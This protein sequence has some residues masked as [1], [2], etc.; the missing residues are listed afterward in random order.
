MLAM[1]SPFSFR[2]FGRAPAD[3]DALPSAPTDTAAQ[4]FP[5]LAPQVG[6]AS[7]IH[8]VAAALLERYRERRAVAA[9]QDPPHGTLLRTLGWI[10]AG[11]GAVAFGLIVGRELRGRYKFRRRTP[12]DFYA[13]AGDERELE[14]GVGI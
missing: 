11:V 12:Y 13:H 5:S 4:V 8:P 9:D 1:K 2:L 3:A 6:V 7:T 14:F 10:S